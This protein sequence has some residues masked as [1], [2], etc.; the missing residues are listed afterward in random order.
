MEY[1]VFIPCHPKD[2]MKIQHVV[3][4][5]QKHM[6]AHEIVL[7]SPDL[8]TLNGN[9]LS[10]VK[11]VHDRDVLPINPEKFAYRPN[12]VYQQFI[13]LFQDVTECDYYITIDCDT[14]INRPVDMFTPEGK[15]IW[16]VGWEQHNEP[17]YRF[18]KRILGLDKIYQG[19]FLA[20]MNFFYRPVIKSLLSHF[21]DDKYTFIE[22]AQE[23]IDDTCYPSE[24]DLY[25]QFAEE[26]FKGLYVKKRLKQWVRGKHIKEGPNWD[27]KEVRKNILSLR[28]EDYDV[29]TMHSWQ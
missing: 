17:Y 23:I 15:P 19:T 28:N 9:R 11:I 2:S 1:D 21:K 6:K 16:Y 27:G 5:V 26:C 8:A 20:D 14:I 3:E 10:K 24:A 12:W 13:K 25:G 22:R 18:N 29:L 4:S 7:C